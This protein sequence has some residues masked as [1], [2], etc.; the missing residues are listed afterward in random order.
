M[1]NNKT[2]TLIPTHCKLFFIFIYFEKKYPL[3]LTQLEKKGVVKIKNDTF[4]GIL[5]NLNKQG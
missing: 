2:F 5:H 3:V 1:K 4:V